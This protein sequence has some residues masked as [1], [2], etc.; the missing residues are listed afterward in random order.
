MLQFSP[1]LLFLIFT[2]YLI[3]H[4]SMVMAPWPSFHFTETFILLEF[5]SSFANIY[6]VYSPIH[7]HINLLNVYSAQEVGRERIEA[8]PNYFFFLY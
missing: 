3:V 6:N 1:S 7:H 5:Y 4:P 8:P 2:L